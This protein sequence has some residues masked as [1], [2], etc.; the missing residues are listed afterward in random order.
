MEVEIILSFLAISWYNIMGLYSL[1]KGS[2]QGNGSYKAAATHGIVCLINSFCGILQLVNLNNI[3][4]ESTSIKYLRYVEWSLC[5]PLMILE[6][7]FALNFS[8]VQIVPLIVLTASFCMCGSIAAFPIAMWVKIFLGVQGTIYCVIV[9]YRMWTNVLEKMTLN[10][11]QK[12]AIANLM[13]ASTIWPFYV[14]T[15]GLGPD[16][17][18]VINAKQEF[19]A[20]TVSS[21]FLK[22]FALSYALIYTSEYT[23][24]YID[25]VTSIILCR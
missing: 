19:I 20:E 3:I 13:M 8:S 10:I 12:V 23:E 6:M 11:D 17:Y 2:F 21:I 25:W 22:T 15:W 14:V 4:I 24:Q 7:S 18:H 1:Y 5:A 16:V 9:L